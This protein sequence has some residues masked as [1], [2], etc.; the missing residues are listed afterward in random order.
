MANKVAGCDKIKFDCK[1]R[2]V[3]PETTNET[4]ARTAPH[5]STLGRIEG[6]Q[7]D[8]SSNLNNRGSERP[9]Q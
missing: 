4:A 6:T 7:Q 3:I 9:N 1:N 5:P 2:P 8:N